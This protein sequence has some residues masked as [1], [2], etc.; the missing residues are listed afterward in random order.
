MTIIFLFSYERIHTISF[1][2]RQ[3]TFEDLFLLHYSVFLFPTLTATTWVSWL[4][5]LLLRKINND[6]TVPFG[7]SSWSIYL[8]G[9]AANS[10]LLPFLT[11]VV[12]TTVSWSR[13]GQCWRPFVVTASLSCTEISRAG[14]GSFQKC[15]T[16]H[17]I[18]VHVQ[19]SWSSLRLMCV[20]IGILGDALSPD[21]HDNCCFAT[22]IAFHH[23]LS[24]GKLLGCVNYLSCG[25]ILPILHVI[26]A[27]AY[28]IPLIVLRGQNQI[29]VWWKRDTKGRK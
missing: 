8:I 23:G 29:A 18:N 21:E 26:S 24:E 25:W 20:G 28:S 9:D 22:T 16:P 5:D 19:P 3:T 14:R 12:P 15:M 27:S 7:F 6:S 10:I 17:R 11:I 13:M 4:S 1:L 2:C